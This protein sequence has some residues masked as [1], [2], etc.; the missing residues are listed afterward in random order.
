MADELVIVLGGK[1]FELYLE[2]DSL[3][4]VLTKV[5]KKNPR[6]VVYLIN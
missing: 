6:V 5:Y 2:S 3:N 1:L 4:K